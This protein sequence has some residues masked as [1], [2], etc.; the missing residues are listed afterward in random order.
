MPDVTGNDILGYRGDAASGLVSDPAALA[1]SG[2]VSNTEQI[3]QTARELAL[4]SFAANQILFRQKVADR[5][6][7]YKML[8]DDQLILNDIPE[9]H[10]PFLDAQKKKITDIWDKYNGD[11]ISNPAH[12]RE[13]QGAIGNA[14]NAIKQSQKWYTWI[15][16]EL[17]QKAKITD[18][19]DQKKMDQH[20]TQQWDRNKADFWALPAP[21]APITNFDLGVVAAKPQYGEPVF[22]HRGDYD[23]ID[24]KIDPEGTFN[25]YQKAWADPLHNHEF[26]NYIFGD[27]QGTY[28][29]FLAGPNADADITR[30]NSALEGINAS[31]GVK[32]GQK[33]Y[34]APLGIRRDNITGKWV[35]DTDRPDQLAAKIALADNP[36]NL[37]KEAFAQQKVEAG[38]NRGKLKEEVRHNKAMESIDWGKINA[39][40]DH[41]AAMTKAPEV[42]KNSAHDFAKNIF[43]QL[44]GMGISYNNGYLIT[45]DKV[46]QMTVEQKKYLGLEN[47]DEADKKTALRPL[48]VTDTDAIFI[49]PS[50]GEV[51]V[52]SNATRYQRP[53]GSVGYTG[54]WDN[55]R[56]TTLT[57]I[58]TNRVNEE[59]RNA[60]THE[61]NSYVPIDTGAGGQSQTQFGGQQ[62]VRGGTQT[63]GGATRVLKFAD[64]STIPYSSLTLD[65]ITAAKNMGAV[66]Q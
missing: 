41:W 23:T 6:A 19:A 61:L 49:D 11:V 62:S 38:I 2:D 54:Q 25:Q 15:N 64:G 40:K 12:Y 17:A 30:I 33:G 21:Y 31:L 66:E 27:P 20:I 44:S 4:Q 65:Q 57:N 56:N 48:N 18:P 24:T 14:K 29:G 42:V 32:A 46:R 37:H 47:Y 43:G 16:G 35:A 22:G 63:G 59:L 50:T 26:S 3:S 36:A 10:R 58:A 13:F 5:D 55:A 7:A 45:P 28:G 34:I 52:M 1:A 9:E 39:E 51:K 53:D 60:G 8:D